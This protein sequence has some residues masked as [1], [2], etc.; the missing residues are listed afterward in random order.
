MSTQENPDTPV[1]KLPELTVA[2]ITKVTVLPNDYQERTLLTLIRYDL[3]N[4]TA[5][6]EQ[7][8]KSYKHELEQLI[9]YYP[10]R[11]LNNKYQYQII[12]L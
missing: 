8:P 4:K 7:A 2:R 5:I 12:K 9:G 10:I 11:F 6:H 3:D 1:Y